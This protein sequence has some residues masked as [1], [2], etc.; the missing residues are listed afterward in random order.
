MAYLD[1]LDKAQNDSLGPGSLNSMLSN[2]AFLRSLL[3]YE[4]LSTGEHNT[5]EVPRVCRRITSAPAVSPSS[6]DIT[7]VTNPATGQYTLTLA[8]D[9]FDTD[10]RLQINPIPESAKP[11]IATYRIN[12]AT[13][14]DV[15][16]K[17]LSST[18]GV[19]GNSWAAVDTKFDVAIHG[20]PLAQVAWNGL[21][22]P[23]ER[24]TAAGGYGLV[25]GGV[26]SSP[27]GWSGMV[28]EMAV[29]Q[30]ALTAEHSSAG[31]HN[32]RQVGRYASRVYY[33]SG[34]GVYK[35]PTGGQFS[36]S[37]TGTGVVEVTYNAALSTPVSTFVC[38]DF[39]RF[40]GAADAR[41]IV[42]SDP[43]F[44][45]GTKTKITIYQWNSTSGWW[46]AADADFFLVVHGS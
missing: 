11:L 32:T 35:A 34:A 17:K 16:I 22:R 4:H 24:A 23:W 27:F 45:A 28:R 12:S 38:A 37:R 15:F 8:T 14:L 44:A 7:A 33:D 36:L 10:I 31:A 20:V 43:D 21:P 42:N 18:L 46:E 2:I 41:T 6:T 1:L 19:A 3:G 26:N 13:S 5:R 25:G 9:R 40:N 29:L 30:A 39:Q